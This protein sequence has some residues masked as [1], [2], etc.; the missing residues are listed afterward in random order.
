V[1]EVEATAI[2]TSAVTLEMI[3]QA[4]AKYANVK[5][6]FNTAV[7]AVANMLEAKRVYDEKPGF[8]AKLRV[9]RRF[10]DARIH[11]VRLVTHYDLAT[12]YRLKGEAALT[13]LYEIVKAE[14]EKLLA[15]ARAEQAVRELLDLPRS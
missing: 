7:T 6:V 4:A 9:D 1:S 3:Q 12:E 8:F 2:P 5:V 14:A 15:D 10:S 11:M 13:E